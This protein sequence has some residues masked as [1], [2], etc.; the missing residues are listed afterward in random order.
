MV[1]LHNVYN[2]YTQ[3]LQFKLYTGF[4]TEGHPQCYFK[5]I[6][7][8]TMNNLKKL[9]A[10]VLLTSSVAMIAA[11]VMAMGKHN[12]DRAGNKETMI[13]KAA[14]RLELSESQVEQIK[15]ILE[16]YKVEKTDEQIAALKAQ[17]TETKAQLDAILSASSFDAEAYE[18]LLDAKHETAKDNQVN[19]AQMQFEIS[20]VLTPEQAQMLEKMKNRKS[21]GKKG[22]HKAMKGDKANQE[23]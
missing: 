17:R 18:A 23:G 11:P 6:R 5:Y 10:A 3:A 9:A 4:I 14:E 15:V 2:L 16:K 8:N 21:K 19:R 7:S 22:G 13:L 20:Q 12:G 1:S